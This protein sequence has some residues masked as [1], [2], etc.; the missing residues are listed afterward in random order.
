MATASLSNET[1]LKSIGATHVVGRGATAAEEIKN[2]LGGATSIV[3][4]GIANEETQKLGIAVT[5][6]D[7]D[8]ILSIQ[9]LP[10]LD[11]EGTRHIFFTP[12]PFFLNREFSVGLWKAISEFLESGELKVSDGFRR[13]V[14]S[15]N[16]FYHFQPSRPFVLS[17]GLL[18]IPE[19]LSRLKEGKVSGGKVVVHSWEE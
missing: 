13:A 2:V 4:D 9:P 16:R 6:S 14:L 18:S 5:K 3:W 19:G 7:A 11:N 17:G 1:F 8:I 10:G 12:G 15:S